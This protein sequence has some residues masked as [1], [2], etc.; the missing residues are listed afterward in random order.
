MFALIVKARFWLRSLVKAGQAFVDT[1]KPSGHV[2]V[3]LRYADGPLEG[4]VARVLRGRN[5]VTGFVSFPATPPYSG[6][7]IVRRLIVPAAQAGS[8]STNDDVTVQYC[9]LGDGTAAETAADTDL[10]SAISP[11]TLKALAEVEY[12]TA[13]PYVTFIFNYDES[14]ANTEISEMCLRSGS[15]PADFW[16]RKTITPFTK[17]SEFTMQVRWQIRV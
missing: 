14:E 13:N 11:S 15:T 16:A 6:R 17:T 8:L 3:V 2:E 10:Q 4:Q 7:D 1:L 12:D 5:V 9:E